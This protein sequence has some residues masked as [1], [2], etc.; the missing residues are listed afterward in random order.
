MSNVDSAEA[1][2]AVGA[3]TENERAIA[4]SSFIQVI[5]YLFCCSIGINNVPVARSSAPLLPPRRLPNRLIAC[6]RCDALGIECECEEKFLLRLVASA[7]T[8]DA[9]VSCCI[10]CSFLCVC[11]GSIL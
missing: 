7:S 5:G 3:E 10:L 1:A 9:S 2:T 4:Q 8:F 6:E 11:H